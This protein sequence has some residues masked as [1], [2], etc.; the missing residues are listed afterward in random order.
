MLFS[1]LIN[2]LLVTTLIQNN[3]GIKTSLQ[4]ESKILNASLAGQEI[5]HENQQQIIENQKQI[6]TYSDNVTKA[7][8]KILKDMLDNQTKE[9]IAAIKK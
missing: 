4:Q 8:M 9:I 6:F 3:A 7:N 2:V 1:M 5:G